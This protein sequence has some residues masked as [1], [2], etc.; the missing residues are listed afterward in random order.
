MKLRGQREC[1][2][3]GSRWSYYETG[4]PA[5]PSCGSLKSIGLDERS[6]HTATATELDL[7]PVRNAVDSEPVRTV[8]ERAADRCREFTRGYGFIDAGTL[9]P[10]DDEY[11]AA[12]ELKYVA[13]ELARR[14]ETTDDERAHFYGL[15]RADHGERPERAPE[16]LRSVRGLAAANAIRAYRADL[17]TYL[18]ATPDP[19]A[20]RTL[21]L[22]ADHVRRVRALEG[23]ID[24]DDVKR[25]VS[26]AREIGRYLDEDDETALAGADER[27]SR[28]S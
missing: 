15:L 3:C 17:R 1:T 26:A 2:A 4:D 18:D 9:T 25:L 21:E 10:L 22:L 16:S 24:P 5:C 28:L 11:L 7:A 19:A 23:D 20:E 27:L 13:S 6:L 8:A 14:L 12:M